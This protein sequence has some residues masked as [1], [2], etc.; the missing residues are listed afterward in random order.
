[1]IQK[2][3]TTTPTQVSTLLFD[4][5]IPCLATGHARMLFLVSDL[6]TSCF[7][8]GVGASIETVTTLPIKVFLLCFAPT[9]SS[10]G[11][12]PHFRIQ[13]HRLWDVGGGIQPAAAPLGWR[14]PRRGPEADAQEMPPPLP[15]LPLTSPAPH[16]SLLFQQP[17]SS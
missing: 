9:S 17:V 5:T 3:E 6:N 1:M 16:P 11:Q 4:D 10:P 7:L 8:G 14:G 2:S 15:W 13:T 12:V